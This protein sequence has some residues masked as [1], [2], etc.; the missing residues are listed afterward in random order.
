MFEDISFTFLAIFGF[1]KIPKGISLYNL[2]RDI[3]LGIWETKKRPE[4]QLN[5]KVIVKKVVFGG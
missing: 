5:P 4:N 1:C 2:Y 3:P